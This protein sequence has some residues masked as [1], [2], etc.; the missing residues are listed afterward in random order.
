MIALDFEF[1]VKR[2]ES[3]QGPGFIQ[4]LPPI[5]WPAKGPK[6]SRVV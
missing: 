2:I 6:S 5:F 3:A 4:L 1:A